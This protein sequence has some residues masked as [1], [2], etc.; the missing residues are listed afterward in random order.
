VRSSDERLV[1]FGVL[2]VKRSPSC[3]G[4]WPR[5]GP[6]RPTETDRAVEDFGHTLQPNQ[7]ASDLYPHGPGSLAT[8][9]SVVG[10]AP[11][12]VSYA[13]DHR[14]DI[15]HSAAWRAWSGRPPRYNCRRPARRLGSP[16]RFWHRDA[17][18]CTDR[19]A[20]RPDLAVDTASREDGERLRKALP[21]PAPTN[22]TTFWRHCNSFKR[23][24]I[25]NGLLII[26][27]LPIP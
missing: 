24:L 1:E 5:P 27:T 12:A 3:F 7:D 20:P 17:A 13:V 21:W 15:S 22:A 23:G 14:T 19:L 26:N 16:C 8:A 25:I 9:I 4:I 6:E 10:S 11:D 2:L 18:R